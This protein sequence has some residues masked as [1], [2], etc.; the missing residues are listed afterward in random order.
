MAFK[1]CEDKIF[2]PQAIVHGKAS[3]GNIGET[4]QH[5]PFYLINID[6][7]LTLSAISN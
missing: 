1:E 2:M 5:E 7:V 3:V 6:D 4:F